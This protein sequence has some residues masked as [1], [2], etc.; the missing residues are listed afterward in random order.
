MVPVPGQS[1]RQ[2]P[3]LSPQ[4][5]NCLMWYRVNCR[6]WERH[7]CRPVRRIF[8]WRC[9]QT[10]ADIETVKCALCKLVSGTSKTCFA[11]LSGIVGGTQIGRERMDGHQRLVSQLWVRL[12][13]LSGPGH[14]VKLVTQFLTPGDTG[15]N[16]SPCPSKC[17]GD[18]TSTFKVPSKISSIDPVI[19]SYQAKWGCSAG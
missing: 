4:K 14:I 10:C 9:P 12:G 16:K 15:K 13:L 1:E 6:G 5:K 17:H 18:W 8:F 11:M 19:F 7:L 2:I 3:C